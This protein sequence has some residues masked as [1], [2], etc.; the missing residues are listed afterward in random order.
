ME[1]T[2]KN[3]LL[4]AFAAGVVVFIA[5]RKTDKFT[6]P[7]RTGDSVNAIEQKFFNTHPSPD[8]SEKNNV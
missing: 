7:P 6:P 1:P 8:A 5:C 4:S 3:I 2:A